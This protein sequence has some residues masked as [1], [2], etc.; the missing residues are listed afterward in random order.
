MWSPGDGPAAQPCA[1]QL[2][3]ASH[4]SPDELCPQPTS[5]SFK[6]V[7]NLG[8]CERRLILPGAVSSVDVSTLGSPG[9]TLNRASGTLSRLIHA[10]LGPRVVG[11]VPGPKFSQFPT[12]PTL[13]RTQ[14]NQ[15]AEAAGRAAAQTGAFIVRGGEDALPGSFAVLE[16]EA[17]R[18]A[19]ARLWR[20]VLA[21]TSAARASPD[22]RE[23]GRERGFASITWA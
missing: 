22:A 20:Q 4:N 1:R 5:F 21:R 23:P 6:P 2:G 17:P 13:A 14:P 3:N 8:T 10:T 18:F 7:P 15:E 12:A 19:L 9:S 16:A 11:S